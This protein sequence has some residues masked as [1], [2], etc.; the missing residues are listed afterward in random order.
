[1]ASFYAELHVAGRVYPV[2][3]CDYS[4]HQ[5]TDQRGRV[6]TKVYSQP[7]DIWLTQVPRDSF[8]GAWA[9]DPYKRC[10]VDIVFRDANGGQALETLHLAGAYC[11]QYGQYFRVGGLSADLQTVTPASYQVSLM[12]SDPDGYHWHAGGPGNYQAAAPREYAAPMPQAGL[13]AAP[14]T[15][16]QDL[17]AKEQRYAKRQSLLSR[18]R[19]RLADLAPLPTSGA[20][21]AT[22]DA[23]RT[24]PGTNPVL[25]GQRQADLKTAAE[26][27]QAAKKMAAERE[28]AQAAVARL[29]RNNVAVERARLSEH[30][31][32]S[33]NK[34]PRP[35]PLGWH[36]LTAQELAR[37]GITPAMLDNPASGFK[38]A[39]YES[40]FERPPKL[41]VAYAGTEDWPDWSTNLRQGSGLETK[42]YNM[43]MKLAQA[44]LKTSKASEVDF[45]GHSLGG[46]LASAATAVTGVKGYTFNAAGLHPNT[47]GRAP[48]SI[49]PEEMLSRGGLI[50]AYH[51]LADPLTSLQSGMQDLGTVLPPVPGVGPLGPEALGVA[52]ALP[53]ARGWRHK[54]KEFT[55][56]NPLRVGKDML[57]EG[58]GVDPELVDHI[59]AQKAEDA[60]TLSQYV[61]DQP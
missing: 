58:H 54:W 2:L 3:K 51:S 23:T 46:G 14:N 11:V 35:E 47:V 57:L 38:A 20:L 28:R 9:G 1:M 6:I 36:M 4:V 12:L 59:D 34:P 52:R 25:T 8:L 27:Q 16:A 56:H 19:A 44:V 21:A 32:F 42:Q 18:S 26:R 24:D 49:S 33:K 39:L 40:T 41:V 48:Y 50:D 29:D 30:V 53:V 31:Y 45:T 5:A 15:D 7:V 10:A 43:S 61:G 22:T 17:L 37:K 60:A 13:V 55:E